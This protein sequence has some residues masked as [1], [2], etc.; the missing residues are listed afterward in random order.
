MSKSIPL[1]Y[2]LKLKIKEE[3]KTITRN[4]NATIKLN[5]FKVLNQATMKRNEKKK[6]INEET[7]KQ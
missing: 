6:I 7:W 3:K 5:A 4:M 2:T 1:N